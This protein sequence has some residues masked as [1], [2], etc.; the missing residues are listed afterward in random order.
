MRC[1]YGLLEVFAGIE[2]KQDILTAKITM[3]NGIFFEGLYIIVLES[4]DAIPK[5]LYLPPNFSGFPNLSVRLD[6]TKENN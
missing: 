6:L 3:I 4:R 5:V 1:K 2:T